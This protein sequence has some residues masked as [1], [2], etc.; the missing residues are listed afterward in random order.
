MKMTNSDR[1]KASFDNLHLSG[2]F[3]M[4]LA[5]SLE[6]E[7]EDSK[8]RNIRAFSIG[9]IAAIVAV[10]TLACGT[11]CY[12]AD[13]GGIRT[14]IRMWIHGQDES[15][16]VLD[17]GDGS[18]V[19]TD[20]N[21]ENHGF[22][23][24]SM[25]EGGEITTMSAEEIAACMNN[26]AELV[27]EEGRIFFCYRNIREDVTD[28]IGSD[29]TL[30]VHI[31]DPSNPN[32]YFGFGDIGQ[33]SYSTDCSGEAAEGVEYHEVDATGLIPGEPVEALDEDTEFSITTTETE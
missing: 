20:E 32:T 9:R 19:W 8:V 2:D 18:F 33:G 14:T 29:H 25:T 28:L 16:D 30:Y 15:V 1:Y 13:L 10:C 27:S 12:A 3:R 11:V 24:Y 4:R 23:G 17:T 6:K 21:G 5:Q 26:G 7:R 31:S 22:G